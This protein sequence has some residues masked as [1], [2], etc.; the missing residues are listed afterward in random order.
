EADARGRLERYVQLQAALRGLRGV[1]VVASGLVWNVGLPVGG[2]SALSRY[3]DDRPFHAAIWFQAAGDT[4]GQ[5]WSGLFHDADGNA[6]MEFTAPGTPLPR[7]RWTRELNFLGWDAPGQPPTLDLPA[8]ATVRVSVQWREAHDPEFLRHGEDA[9]REPLAD[10]QLVLLHQIDPT[11]MK[12]PADDME[13]VAQ[14]S[15]LPQRLDNQ[16]AAATYEQTLE[17]T[18][19]DA[20]R[21]AVRV[22]G[23]APRGIRPPSAPTLP[24][25]VKTSEL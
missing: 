20:G 19:K 8:G 3:F 16:P 10:L 2:S 11:G 17:F 23:R 25:M 7:E 1:Q 5:S 14:S 18:V 15:G 9:Y 13:V 24:V 6:V 21:Y 12:Q 22:E 4:R